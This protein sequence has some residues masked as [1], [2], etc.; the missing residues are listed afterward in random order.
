MSTRKNAS[1]MASNTLWNALERFSTMGI[2]LL[3]TFILARFLTPADFGLVG[4]LVVF[5]LI[6]NTITESGFGQ[7]LIREREC[8]QLTLSTVFWANLGLS[9]IVY[10]VLYMAAPWIAQWFGQPQL[11]A[12][13]RVTFLV[14]PIGAVGLI[15]NIICTRGLQFRTLFIVSAI[16]SLL[17]CAVAL[18]WAWHTRSVWA[19]VLQNV[20]AYV[21][22]TIGYC[23]A[24][25][26]RPMLQFSFRELRRLFVFARN[27]LVTGL[28][29]NLFNNIYLL[30]I[31]RC[32]GAVETGFFAQ[33][34]RIRMVTSASSTQVVQSVSY[35][36]LSQINHQDEHRL[37]DAYRKIIM[38]TLMLVG[39][40]MTL[41]MTISEDLMELLMGNETWRTSGQ[42]LYALGVAGILF[43]L[44]AVNQNI[45]LVKGLGRTVLWLEVGRRSLMIAL[46]ALTLYCFDSVVW[47]VWSY[48][49]YSF[50]LIFVNLWVCG[51][52]IG[53]SLKEQLKDI[54]PLLTSLTA[55][56]VY[57]QMAN[58][59]MAPLS[60]WQRILIVL[61]T[62][63]ILGLSLLYRTPAFAH[64]WQ[65][66][67]EMRKDK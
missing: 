61:P 48:A 18:V 65:L 52:P 8:S 60:P 17:S 34:D 67:R 50:I 10:V 32:Y 20:V 31:G 27:L 35:P 19:L 45:L 59:F 49:F 4:M 44:H 3:C 9:A 24:T 63:S 36:I 66:L 6:G 54:T 38:V 13:S 46:I 29:G 1:L 28:I 14:I 55:V 16:A 11:V 15:N 30:I 25:H 64:A 39:L 37:R 23:L 42:Y 43:P 33:A 21:L 51:K 62:A 2:Q 26:W 5:T 57:A 53:Y 22:K 40:M 12:I 7:A 41:L 56:L 58:H 47:L